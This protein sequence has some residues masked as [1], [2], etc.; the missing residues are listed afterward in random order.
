MSLGA[1][2]IFSGE[3]SPAPRT[4][5]AAFTPASVSLPFGNWRSAPSPVLIPSSGAASANSTNNARASDTRGW[6][7]TTSLQRRNAAAF[8]F[9]GPMRRPNSDNNA[10]SSVEH[11][12]IATNT[13]MIAP[14][15]IDRTAA[16]GTTS[17]AA[18]ASTTAKP[19]NST[20]VPDVAIAVARAAS[21]VAPS[22][23]SSRK[24]TTTNSE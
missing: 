22:R 6:P 21:A 13:T 10:G 7:T 11:A 14:T 18:S 8:G 24:R 5:C 3:L 19:L 9:A 17:S 12:S 23:S 15:A 1:T 2:R 20:A 16:V 4:S